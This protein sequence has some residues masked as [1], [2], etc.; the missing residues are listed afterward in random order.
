VYSVPMSIDTVSK[1]GT[2]PFNWERLLM[3]TS[4]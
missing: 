1:L 2:V 3:L 4:P